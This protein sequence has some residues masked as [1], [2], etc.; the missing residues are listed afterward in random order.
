[1]KH[2]KVIPFGRDY[3]R[4][5]KFEM[6]LGQSPKRRGLADPAVY[7]KYV[8]AGAVALLLCLQ[9]LPDGAILV[10]QKPK[11]EVCQVVSVVDGD[12]VRMWC[13]AGG[14]ETARLVGFDTPELFSPRCAG[15]MVAA[16]KATWAL[17]FALL[18]A[19]EVTVVKQGTDGYGRALTKLWVDGRPVS[20]LM[21]ERGLARAYAG[22][23]REGW[24]G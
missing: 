2:R 10:S 16:V 8:L 24:C 19:Q 1:M 18:R 20:S 12:T 11:G 23:R 21:I 5:V 6:G 17:R 4:P 15:E 13:P 22:G 9:V 14:V 3:R 7:L